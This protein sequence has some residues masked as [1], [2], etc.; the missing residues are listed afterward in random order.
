MARIIVKTVIIKNKEQIV[1]FNIEFYIAPP[2]YH[3]NYGNENSSGEQVKTLGQQ[4][5]PQQ[6]ISLLHSICTEAY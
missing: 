6:L 4:G 2:E 1:L 5:A 3:T